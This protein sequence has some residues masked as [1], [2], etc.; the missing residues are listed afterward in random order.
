MRITTAIIGL[1]LILVLLLGCGERPFPTEHL[2]IEGFVRAVEINRCPNWFGSD[3][4][5]V[6]FEDGRV[7]FFL[8]SLPDMVK[9]GF[10]NRI[11]FLRTHHGDGTFSDKI[12]GLT[13]FPETEKIK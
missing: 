10:N 2:S 1:T 7:K 12:E 4:I 3:I 13:Q 11:F 6:G 8:N 9:Q 5:V